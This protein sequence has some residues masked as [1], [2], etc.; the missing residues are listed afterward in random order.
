MNTNDL[1]KELDGLARGLRRLSSEARQTVETKLDLTYAAN[2]PA[3]TLEGV[4]RAIATAERQ[5]GPRAR[6]LR[7]DVF[8]RQVDT[9]ASEYT[10][11]LA[12]LARAHATPID[13]ARLSFRLTGRPAGTVWYGEALGTWNR[14]P[15]A[16]QVYAWQRAARY[17]LAYLIPGYGREALERAADARAGIIS[18]MNAGAEWAEKRSHSW[19]LAER[20]SCALDTWADEHATLS[21]CIDEEGKVD[22]VYSV[23]P[24]PYAALL[25]AVAAGN[26]DPIGVFGPTEAAVSA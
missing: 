23:D 5:A 7:Q 25:D 18:P 14:T 17:A 6:D 22:A 3:L 24:T 1:A 8:D 20:Y 4:R 13:G 21:V 10:R 19:R 11:T 12:G 15:I 9:L 26:A 2:L 16:A